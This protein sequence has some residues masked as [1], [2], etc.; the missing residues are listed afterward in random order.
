MT[1]ADVDGAH[2]TSLLLTFFF[3]EMKE[4]VIAGNLYLAQPPLFRIT[5]KDLT[6]YAMDDE[7]KDEIIKK[8]FKSNS[9][10]EISRFKG[11]GEMPAKQLKETTMDQNNRILIRVNLPRDIIPQ[12]SIFVDD[13]MGKNPEKRLKFIKDKVKANDINFVD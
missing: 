13:V 1:D 6:F 9:K 2:I 11:L 7:H 4:L 12:T 8:N 10:I 5:Q 3:Q